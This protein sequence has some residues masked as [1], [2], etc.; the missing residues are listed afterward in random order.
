M[1]LKKD[2]LKQYESIKN[3]TL[4]ALSPGMSIPVGSDQQ[5]KTLMAAWQQQQNQHPWTGVSNFS[6]SNVSALQD[7]YQQMTRSDVVLSMLSLISSV[8][9]ELAKRWVIKHFKE[10]NGEF[11]KAVDIYTSKDDEDLNKVIEECAREMKI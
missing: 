7:T 1:S 6:S 5:A 9:L 8:G 3:A 10:Y 2:L 4:G 11:L